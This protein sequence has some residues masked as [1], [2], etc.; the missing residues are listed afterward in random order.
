MAN[1]GAIGR[2]YGWKRSLPDFR[3]HKFAVPAHL[4]AAPLPPSVDLRPKMPA[5]YD[6]SELGSCTANATGGLAHYL[7][8]KE[9]KPAYVP[10]RLFIYYNER[11][12][13]DSVNEDSGASLRDGMKVLNK[14][15]APHETIWP[16]CIKKFKTR[17]PKAAY[18]D[19]LN[20]LL[21]KYESVD[22]T[23]VDLM[24]AALAAGYPIAGG[25]SVYESFESDAVAKTGIVPMPGKDDSA[26]GGHAILVVG[27]D[28][29]KKWYIVRNSWGSGW[30]DKGYFYMPYDFFSNPDLADDFWVGK[31]IK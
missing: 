1:F 24:K 13:E 11:V 2:K 18:A 10:S 17:P 15:G 19:G 8:I 12:L 26:L 21:V 28:D 31:L 25:F 9:G 6:Q 14:Q 4:V 3:D 27:Y 5:P 7:F 23:K 22:N 29:A 20:H 30:G 16:Y